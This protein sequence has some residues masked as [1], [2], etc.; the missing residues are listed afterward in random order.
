MSPRL[1]TPASAISRWVVRLLI[2]A[3][4]LYFVWRTREIIFTVLSA[5]VL[6]AAL[7]PVVDYL[8]R[9]RLR[10]LHPKTQRMVATTLVFSAFIGL[11]VLT[12]VWLVAPVGHEFGRLHSYTASIKQTIA[13]FTQTVQEVY[14]GLPDSVKN[15][16]P[17]KDSANFNQRLEAIVSAT[18]ASAKVWLSHLWEVLVVP[19][20][21]F[22]F[23][24][25]STSLKKSFVSLFAARRRREVLTLLRD[26]S[27]VLR[28]YIA[29]QILL[30]IIA[31]AVM[32]ALLTFWNVKY[33]TTLAVLAGITR[34]VPIVGPIF[35]GAIIF[36]I[37]LASNVKL[38]VTVLII[39]SILHFV[40][41]KII[42]PMLLGDMMRLHPAVLL[43]SILIGYEFF[44]VM[45]MFLA[46]PVAA[47]ATR[48]IARYYLERPGRTPAT[49]NLQ[50]EEHPEPERRPSGAAVA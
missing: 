30:C 48:I 32:F 14:A 41:S 26:G 18:L 5:A 28:T 16:L 6:A 13:N 11:C 39:F 50:Q 10:F 4:V 38:A 2:A 35:S 17:T 24:S 22:Y 36:L 29:G 44:G 23:V 45:G 12:I 25:D 7:A 19:V 20:L 15:A 1:D 3:G 47:M 33:A 42:M 49:I 9:R 21:A 37:I 40:E 8:C 46:A 34:A 43:I 31:G 27:R